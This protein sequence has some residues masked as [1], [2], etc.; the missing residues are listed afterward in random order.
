MYYQV[1]QNC[2]KVNS[3]RF[4]SWQ[5]CIKE[6]AKYKKEDC[7]ILG[8]DEDGELWLIKDRNDVRN[9]LDF[10]LYLINRK[11]K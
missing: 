9:Y 3:K 11:E 7:Y 2:K 1:Y 8:T 5:E 6:I 10:Y 4:E